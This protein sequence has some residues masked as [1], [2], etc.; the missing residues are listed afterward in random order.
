M[1]ERGV[2]YIGTAEKDI[3]TGKR[4]SR[5]EEQVILVNDL[6]NI[7]IISVVVQISILTGFRS[8][9]RRHFRVCDKIKQQLL[10]N[11]S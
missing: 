4:N 5:A 2:R 3:G 8:L 6:P 1:Y 10:S 9:L 7:L 11:K